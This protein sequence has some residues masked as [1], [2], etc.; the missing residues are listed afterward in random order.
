[1]MCDLAHVVDREHAKVVVLLRLAD[2]TGPMQTEAAKAGFY[3]TPYGRFPKIQILTIEELF[4]GKR[5]LLPWLDREA[6][7]Q[8]PRKIIDTQGKFSFG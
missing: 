1:M 2:P 3:E 5:P 6:F 7:K 4:N 8:V